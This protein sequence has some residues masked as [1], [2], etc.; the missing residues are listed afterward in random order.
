MIRK[1][2]RGFTLIE[3]M[4]VV[5]IIGILAAIAIPN[6]VKFQCRSK[7]GEAR[8]NLKAAYVAEDAYRGRNGQYHSL[9]QA[10][11]TD[12]GPNDMG[13]NLLGKLRY[14]YTLTNNAT[15]PPT[16]DGAAAGKTGIDMSGDTWSIDENNHL[17]PGH[18]P[19]DSTFCN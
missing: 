13:F 11:I 19:P 5:A 4:I 1:L 8:T 14:T 10:A 16:F 2:A 7:Q 9:G 15:V 17:E 6:F 12:T 3:L 18:T